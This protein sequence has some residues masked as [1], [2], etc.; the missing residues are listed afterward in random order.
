MNIFTISHLARI[1][2]DVGEGILKHGFGIAKKLASDPVVLPENAVLAYGK[3]E[4]VITAIHQHAFEHFIQI[5]RFGR[6]VLEVPV[7]LT[8][9]HINSNG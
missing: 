5:Q 6:H 4:T 1:G 9:I 8:G 3:D 7:Q 2:I